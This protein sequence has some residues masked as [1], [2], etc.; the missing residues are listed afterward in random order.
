MTHKTPLYF[1]PLLILLSSIAWGGSPTTKQE[2]IPASPDAAGRLPEL[3]G[4]SFRFQPARGLGR[5][6][7][8]T[9]R[10]VSDVI[11]VGDTYYIW[12]SKVD[13]RKLAPH[14]RRMKHQGYVAT[15][16]YAVSKDEGHTWEEKGEALGLGAPGEFDSF[17]VFTP[18][19]LKFDGQYY[20]YYDAVKPT[21]EKKGTFQNNS[22]TDRTAMGL[23]V[24]DSPDGPFVRIKNNP[25]LVPT[26]PSTDN[27][28]PSAFDSYRV[29]DSAL[30]VRDYDGDGDLDV[31]LYYKGRNFDHGRAGPGKTRMGL[32]IADTPEGPYV[33]AN[34]GRPILTGSHEVMIWPHREGVA[35]YASLTQTFEYAPD[36]ID[37]L[38]NRLGAKA[39][40]KPIAPGCYRPDLTNPAA[41][42]RGI[43]W[44]ISMKEPGGP[45]PYLLRFEV[46]AKSRRK[47]ARSREC[48]SQA[49]RQR[50]AGGDSSATGDA[51]RIRP[52]RNGPRLE[53]SRGCYGRGSSPCRARRTVGGRSA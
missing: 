30:L 1:L 21:D 9:R 44:G 26:Q 34:G 2:K 52:R 31:G 40:P 8:V 39:G 5:E 25:I 24:S 46:D 47:G 37:F 36:G 42:G 11:R 19:I 23:A 7:G 41:Y 20:L 43:R 6:E 12:Y 48:L 49:A 3:F 17:A 28:V 38:S 16:W 50:P 33:R 18:N 4:K 14:N 13:H 15:I 27:N 29:D 32:A 35:A 53:A 22:T 45:Y 51:G 10:D